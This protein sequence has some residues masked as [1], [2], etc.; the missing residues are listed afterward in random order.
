MFIQLL[1]FMLFASPIMFQMTRSLFGSWVA[2]YEGLPSVLGLLLH[3]VVFIVVTKILMFRMSQFT[4]RE[5]QNDE[6]TTMF[7]KNRFVY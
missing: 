6:N 7:Q 2:N 4:S 3:A 5:D 1:A